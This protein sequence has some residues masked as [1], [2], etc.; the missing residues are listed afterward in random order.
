MRA[1]AT[2]MLMAALLES[3]EGFVILSWGPKRLW[4]PNSSFSLASTPSTPDDSFE[5]VSAETQRSGISGEKFLDKE[6]PVPL[7]NFATT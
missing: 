3:D 4:S 1:T 2:K 7:R 6:D 5:Y